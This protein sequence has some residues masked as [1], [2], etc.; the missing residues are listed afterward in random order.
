MFLPPLQ[1]TSPTYVH[2]RAGWHPAMKVSDT[3]PGPAQR[4]VN[5]FVARVADPEARYQATEERRRR[6]R[7]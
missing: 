6:P 4:K 1:V 2:G 5:Q 7:N 3:T